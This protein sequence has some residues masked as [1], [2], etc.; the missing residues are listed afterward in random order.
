MI[1]AVHGQ[2]RVSSF[3]ELFPKLIVATIS[4]LS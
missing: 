4:D 3:C 1:Y 2:G